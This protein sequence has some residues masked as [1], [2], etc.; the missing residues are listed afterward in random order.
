MT[1]TERVF[2]DC[3][4]KLHEQGIYP[5][6]TKINDFLGRSHR[7]VKKNN[8]NGQEV[9]WRDEMFEEL[10]IKKINPMP[11]QADIDREWYERHGY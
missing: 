7:L 2:K 9:K 3:I 8:I 1:S 5:G 4:R 10:D 6:P 11:T